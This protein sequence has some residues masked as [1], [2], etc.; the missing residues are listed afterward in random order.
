MPMFAR[1]VAQI[2]I[3]NPQNV[4]FGTGLTPIPTADGGP[5]DN[6]YRTATAAAGVIAAIPRVSPAYT[7]SQAAGLIGLAQTMQAL[8]YMQVAETHDTGGM[9]IHPASDGTP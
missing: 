4:Q 9:A 8:A 6:E 2:W 7:A 1:D 3:D 5:W